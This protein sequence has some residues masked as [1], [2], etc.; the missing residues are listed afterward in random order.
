MSVVIRKE[1]DHPA[2]ITVKRGD[3]KWEVTEK[4][5]DKLP[6]DV[7]PHVERM[8]GRGPFGIVGNLSPDMMQ[9]IA[10]SGVPTLDDRLE[11]R[12]EEMDKRIDRIMRALEQSAKD[13]DDHGKVF[14]P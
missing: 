7:R 9:G 13:R 12:L 2:T 10:R 3:E 8:L 6:A 4:E 11:K 1:G 14:Y 5:L